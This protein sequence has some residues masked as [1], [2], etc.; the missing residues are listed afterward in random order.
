M[1]ESIPESHRDLLSDE[2]KAFAFLATLM[3]DGS[4]QLTPVWFDTQ[5]EFIR[6]NTARGRVKDR[7]MTERP[8]AA[9]GIMDPGNP[10]RYVQIR[11][12]IARATEEG[13]REHIDRLA[14]KYLG[15][16]EYENYQGERR[17][18]YLLLPVSVS[19]MG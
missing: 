8:H 1:L 19:T 4:P 16:P 5:D 10:Y 2:K 7:N 13:A 17:V 6:I 3:P 18:M 14:W 11:V 12:S 15:T 9:L